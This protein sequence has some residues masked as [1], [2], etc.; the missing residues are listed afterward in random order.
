ALLGAYSPRFLQA[1]A[2]ATWQ[3]M[4]GVHRRCLLLTYDGDT[5]EMTN[6]L[7]DLLDEVAANLVGE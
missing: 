2:V 4:L 1:Q 7:A 5:T 6:A 3:A